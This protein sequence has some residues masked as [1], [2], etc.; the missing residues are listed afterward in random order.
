MKRRDL[1]A[2]IA[3]SPVAN[4]AAT[5]TAQAS[6]SLYRSSERLQPWVLVK[7]QT[8]VPIGSEVFCENG[9]FVAVIG[10]PA[11]MGWPRMHDRDGKDITSEFYG[12]PFPIRCQCGA[13]AIDRERD[14]T[15]T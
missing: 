6:P 1:L 12:H 2:L 5:Q 13:I 10:F 3:V 4:L 11:D 7:G 15:G 8:S 9:H 14:W